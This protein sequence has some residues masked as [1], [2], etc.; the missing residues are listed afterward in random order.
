MYGSARGAPDS[1]GHLILQKIKSLISA[2]YCR[3]TIPALISPAKRPDS[4]LLNR[5]SDGRSQV[6]KPV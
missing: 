3:V 5:W 1:V 6:E 4:D 2:P